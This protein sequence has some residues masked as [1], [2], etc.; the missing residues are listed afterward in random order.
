LV[1]ISNEDYKKLIYDWNKTSFDYPRD[2]TI[3]EIFEE[4][5]EKHP[6]NV[7]IVFEGREV[8]Y[9]DLSI[10]VNKLAAYLKT[11]YKLEPDDLISVCLD[12]SEY[13]LISILAV[14]KAGGAYVP[15]SPAYPI[16]RIRF[17]LEDT[18]SKVLLTDEANREKFTAELS[19]T[20]IDIISVN[21]P[22]FKSGLQ[23][24][25]GVELKNEA[26]PGNL[27]YVIYTSGT[28]GTPKGVMIKQHSFLNLI[29]YFKEHHFQEGCNTFSSTN[30]IFDKL[31]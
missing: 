13:M 22:G 20:N 16:E 9:K 11:S 28:T 14:L 1:F 30:Y 12:R 23:E 6:D 3:I 8:S 27:A 7:A 21:N 17:T 24:Y 10:E 4:Q 31:I 19:D 15:V 18:R 29:Y 2:K 5:A 26:T 25:E